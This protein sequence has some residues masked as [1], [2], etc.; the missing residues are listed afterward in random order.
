MLFR[1]SWHRVDADEVWSYHAGAPLRLLIAD[2]DGT[3]ADHALGVDL[4]AGERPQVV[5]PAHAWQAAESTGEY[6]LVSCTVSPGFEFAGF[7]LAPPGWQPGT[8]RDPAD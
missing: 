8:R 3:W 4:A 5:V 2:A 7:R 1:S 6:T